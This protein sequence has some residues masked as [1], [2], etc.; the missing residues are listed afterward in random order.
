MPSSA[1]AVS[2]C[3]APLTVTGLKNHRS[4]LFRMEDRALHLWRRLCGAH[5][6]GL[7]RLD[8]LGGFEWRIR[9][10]EREVRMKLCRRKLTIF[11][12]RI[13]EN[14]LV[15]CSFLIADCLSEDGRAEFKFRFVGRAH[16]VA[17]HL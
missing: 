14:M 6:D 7:G 13:I 2:F 10:Q 4:C 15:L 8:G 12:D 11:F 3:P 16:P 17:H 1:L 5:E 9:K